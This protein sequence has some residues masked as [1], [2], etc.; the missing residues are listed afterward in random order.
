MEENSTTKI[1]VTINNNIT[2]ISNSSS[3]FHGLSDWNYVFLAYIS[4]P[5]MIILNSIVV[6]SSGLILKKGN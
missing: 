5:L 6:I 1:L 2:S 4:P 3:S